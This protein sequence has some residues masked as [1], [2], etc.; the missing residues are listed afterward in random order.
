MLVSNKNLQMFGILFVLQIGIICLVGQCFSEASFMFINL[1]SDRM[2][3]F[4]LI[5]MYMF[6]ISVIE[7]SISYLVTVRIGNRVVGM[8]ERLKR[9]YLLTVVFWGIWFSAALVL[10]VLIFHTSPE[11]SLVDYW[12]KFIKYVLGSLLISHVLIVFRSSNHRGVSENAFIFVYMLFSLE[13]M[14]LVPEIKIQ[15]PLELLFFFSWMV[16]GEN[17]SFFV[18]FFYNILLLGYIFKISTR[19][20]II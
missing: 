3:V 17:L 8:L 13:L 4:L 9:C 19:K 12:C 16:Y 2:L 5:P 7:N 10:S 6:A 11:F 15:T 1:F 14:V 18:L 20:D